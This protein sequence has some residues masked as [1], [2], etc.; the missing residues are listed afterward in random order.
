MTPM[1]LCVLNMERNGPGIS[2]VRA[3]ELEASLSQPV[4]TEAEKEYL[5]EYQECA[6]DGIISDKERRLLDKLR[7]VLGISE[8]R[9]K[10]LEYIELNNRINY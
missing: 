7:N 6:T 10:E 3:A 9:A 5:S 2:D 4:L 1:N 8:E